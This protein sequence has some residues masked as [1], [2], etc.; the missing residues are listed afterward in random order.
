[1][2]AVALLLALAASALLIAGGW[3][4]GARRGRAERDALRA[5]AA[6]HEGRAT[7][8]AE[9]VTAA[10]A[11]AVASARDAAALREELGARIETALRR[12]PSA[13]LKRHLDGLSSRLAPLLERE[14]RGQSL[15]DLGAAARADL[16]K[17]LDGI[18]DRGRFSTV[19]LTDS[20]GLVLTHNRAAKDLD[21]HAGVAALLLSLV[22]RVT[23]SESPA[24]IAA[25]LRDEAN[26]SIVHRIFRLGGERYVLT[27]VGLGT[28]VTPDA[29]DPALNAID[30]A[31]QT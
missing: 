25:V 14:R 23:T 10:E 24:P 12:D 19:L 3:I 31:L 21:L 17:V 22:D 16:P 5:A 27:A 13:E 6:D 9:A 15:A 28:S 30:R 8:L 26:R 18:A 29:L 20:A 7:T 2:S 1:V 4:L 11:R